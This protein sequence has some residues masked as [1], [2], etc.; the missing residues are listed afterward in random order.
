MSETK[1]T[2]APWKY[3][4]ATD[5]VDCEGGTICHGIGWAPNG[6]LLAAA[7]DLY[8]ALAALEPWLDHI[9]G[10]IG[11]EIDEARAALA[12]ARGAP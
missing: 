1:W 12:A 11:A 4:R 5:Q 6:P 2:K 9:P 8:A 10:G 7:P 3:D